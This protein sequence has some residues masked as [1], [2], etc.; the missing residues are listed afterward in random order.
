MNSAQGRWLAWIGVAVLA[1]V[2]GSGC[3]TNRGIL[4]VRIDVPQDPESGKVSSPILELPDLPDVTAYEL[5]GD[6]VPGVRTGRGED[7]LIDR[8]PFRSEGMDILS[9]H[10]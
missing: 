5:V 3:A 10:T 8:A 6:Q 9:V 2:L 7:A 4:D 1:G